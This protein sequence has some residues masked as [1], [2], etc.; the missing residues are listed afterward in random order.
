MFSNK[1]SYS[2]SFIWRLKKA[3]TWDDNTHKMRRGFVWCIHIYCQFPPFLQSTIGGWS[4][5]WTTEESFLCLLIGVIRWCEIQAILWMLSFSQMVNFGRLHA[6]GEGQLHKLLLLLLEE[7]SSIW[8]NRLI[9]MVIM[10]SVEQ[11]FSMFCTLTGFATPS[12]VPCIDMMHL[13]CKAAQWSQCYQY[14]LSTLIK[15]TPWN[16]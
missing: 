7:M 15:L 10:V 13:Y 9:I 1:I 16:R 3:D 14:C 5:F 11:R 6:L 12:F 4:K 2:F 8:C